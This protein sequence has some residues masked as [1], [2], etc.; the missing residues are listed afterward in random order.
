[1]SSN[2]L[3]K[4]ITNLGYDNT[5]DY[6][7]T[8]NEFVFKLEEDYINLYSLKKRDKFKN[9]K[10]GEWLKSFKTYCYD[11]NLDIPD[12]YFNRNQLSDEQKE[13][14][15]NKL[16]NVSLSKKYERMFGD[17]KSLDVS[18]DYNSNIPNY[19]EDYKFQVDKLNLFLER[20]NLPLLNSDSK[21]SELKSALDL[22]L[23]FNNHHKSATHIEH[24]SSSTVVN[25]SLTISLNL[26][27]I[28]SADDLCKLQ[29]ELLW[30]TKEFSKLPSKNKTT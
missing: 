30:L 21:P 4:K 14:L 5:C 10:A 28:L 1:M 11:L 12:D 22:Y 20:L 19:N 23:K 13:E 27:T 15:L 7:S 2:F 26:Q 18:S 9:T 8:F 25:G 17:N 3:M 29:S 24:T 16:L 6:L